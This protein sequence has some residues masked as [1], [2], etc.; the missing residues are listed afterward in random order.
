M[1]RHAQV[2]QSG[3]CRAVIAIAIGLLA[4][5]FIA[6]TLLVNS[7]TAAN[8]FVK[9][10]SNEQYVR[11]KL[12]LAE[13][14]L[15]K[16]AVQSDAS[17][18]PSNNNSNTTSSFDPNS[19]AY[20]I[21]HYHKTGHHLSRQLRDFLV[22]GTD[23]P[24]ISNNRENA[25]QFRSHE[26]S[27]GCPRAMELSPGIIAVQA[28]PNLFCDTNVLA[29]FLLRNGDIYKEKKGV[30]VIH[31]V[32]NP[33]DLA[34]S[35]FIYHAQFPTPEVWVKKIDPCAEELWFD[36]QTMGDLVG[37]TLLLGEEPILRQDD[38]ESLHKVC[39]GLYQT[40]AHEGGKS[41]DWNYYTH[42]RHLDPKDALSLATSHMMIQGKSGGD[43]LRM[44]NNMVKLKQVQRL[45]DQIRIS[46]HLVPAKGHERMIQVMTLSMAEFM[47]EPK[48]ATL[49]FLDFALADASAAEVKERIATEYEQ[50][51]FEKVKAGDEHITTDK[52]IQN[53]LKQN[54]VEEKAMLEEYLRGHELFGR[55]LGNVEQLVQDAL[56]E[57]GGHY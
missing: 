24:P 18:E 2:H 39:T 30:K 54:I 26:E 17:Q 29:E 13:H 11:R 43:I 37:P 4:S 42:L 10:S 34:V 8:H 51:Y 3:R 35:N 19:Y 16:T 32:R 50:S 41:K 21:I 36:R 53:G 9:E 22:A 28:A 38:F 44:A 23:G 12:S 7:A 31:L 20:L 6:S 1:T 48:A 46:Q 27:T 25:F 33:F 55:V 40:G 52:N 49:R 47:K 5:I 15:P 56:K 45:E 57:S 14:A